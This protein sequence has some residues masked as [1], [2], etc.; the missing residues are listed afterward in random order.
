L[1]ITG[2]ATFPGTGVWGASGRN[3]ALKILSQL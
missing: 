3:A 1:Y 2:A